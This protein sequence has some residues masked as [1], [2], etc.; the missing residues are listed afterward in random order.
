MDFSDF[1]GALALDTECLP[2]PWS[3]GVW[4]EELRSPYSVYFAIEDEGRIVAQIG[5]KLILDEM[6]VMTVAVH[7]QYRRRGHARALMESVLDANPPQAREV[8]LEVRPS[9][10]SARTLYESFGFETTVRRPGYYGD[11][12]AVLMT[13][14]LRAARRL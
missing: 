12:D 1:R 11:E 8:H 13:L 2:R 14:D 5:A 7:P 4:S 10:T 6:H 9:N 3:A